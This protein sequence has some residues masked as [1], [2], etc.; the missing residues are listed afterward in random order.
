MLD[1]AKLHVPSA[2]LVV[3]TA[4]ALPAESASVD[5]LVTTSVFHY[6]PDPFAARREFRRVLRPGGTLVV[7][8][9]SADFLTMRLQARWSKATERRFCRIYTAI[10]LQAILIA[11]GFDVQ[12]ETYKINWYWGL[13]TV[14]ATKSG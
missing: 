11:A 5:W 2:H 1:Q 12:V 4:E 8:D 3:G 13:L 7:T 10:E 9:W 6:V 14:R